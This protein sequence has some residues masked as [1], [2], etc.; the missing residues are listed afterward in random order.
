MDK[1]HFV[2]NT[3]LV[4]ITH[5]QNCIKSGNE[6]IHSRLFSHILHPEKDYILCG[7]SKEVKDGARIHPEHVVPCAVLRNESFRLLKEGKQ[8][9]YIAKL[10][11]KHWKLAYISK[12]QANSLDSK[13]KLNLKD[14]MPPGWCM[15]YGDTFARLDKAG[16]K[17]LPLN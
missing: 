12:D 17:L 2:F 7:Q 13:N 4:L 6:G 5:F 3:A 11:S 15:E 1:E 10:L 14:T 16:I 9:E 8:P